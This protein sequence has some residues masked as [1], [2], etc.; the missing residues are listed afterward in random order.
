[1]SALRPLTARLNRQL[2]N[3]RTAISSSQIPC[4]YDLST[5]RL[6]PFPKLPKA[7]MATS[8]N[9]NPQ[10]AQGGNRIS[11]RIIHDHREL[12]DFYNKIKSAKTA[13]SQIEWQNQFTW[14]LARHSIAEE[15]TVYPAMEKY[16]GDKG[17]EMAEKDRREHRS[18]CR[19]S[20]STPSN[21]CAVNTDERLSRSKKPSTPSKTSTLQTAVSC[22]PSINS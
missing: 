4:T 5:H 10:G 22:R 7:A 13:D 19:L 18:V 15:L 20:C 12:S 9:D 17:K 21:T 14:E 6:P 2:L 3:P 8:A 1:M 11:D 16:L